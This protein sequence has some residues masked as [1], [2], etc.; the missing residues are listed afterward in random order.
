VTA[1][2][3]AKLCGYRANGNPSTSDNNDA[4][5]I[6]W[7]HALFAA[8]GV[9]EDKPETPLV[10]SM[11]E[12]SAAEHLAS[13][14]PDLVVRQSRPALVFDQYRHLDVF[15]RFAGTYRGPGPE[16]AWITS[17][18]QRLPTSSAIEEIA[19]KLIAAQIA[20]QRDHD[21]VSQLVDTMPEESMLKIDI[22]VAAQPPVDRLLIGLSSKW[23][24]RTDRAQDCVSQGS[25]LVNLRRGHMPHFAVLTM[26]PRPAMLRLI[27][28]GSGSID[29]VY[30][31]ALPELRAA[32]VAIE[33]SRGGG[34]R[35]RATLE[36]M[37]SQ[38]RVRPYQ[39]LVDEVAR[40]PS[41]D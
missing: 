15:R 30:H 26:E 31:V 29:C 2:F 11:L 14:R 37:I 19:A 12:R 8:L 34:W 35:P 36:R 3:A 10:G 28:Y 16:L 32:A 33:Q 25:K 18:V 40:L 23:S 4:G 24:L 20:A 9:P 6:E 21:L 27:A 41:W 17:E 1:P 7:G 22:T 13:V 39:D 5:S 38:R